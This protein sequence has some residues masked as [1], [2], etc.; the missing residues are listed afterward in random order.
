MRTYIIHKLLHAI[1]V[2]FVVSFVSFFLLFYT[3]DPAST[4]R[5]ANDISLTAVE[6]QTLVHWIEAGAPRGEGPDPLAERPPPAQP[7]WPLGPPDLVLSDM[8][9]PATGHAATD[10]L[11]TIALAEAAADYALDALAPGGGLV[12]KVLQGAD[13]P[14]L[15]ARLQRAF[16]RVRRCKP[17]A[18]RGDSTELY[19][20]AADRRAD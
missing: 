16:G 8:A 7:E 14:A 4:L 1:G 20:V 18:S 10:H 6:K 11:R 5:F 17:A 15:F 9:A 19:L 12:V 2:C 13:E 3:A